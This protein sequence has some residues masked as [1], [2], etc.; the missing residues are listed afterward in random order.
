MRQKRLFYLLFLLCF[1][2]TISFSQTGVRFDDHFIDATMRVDYF[3]TGDARELYFSIDQIYKQ[4]G[5]A[6]NPEKL[7]DRSNGGMY[8][9]KVYSLSSNELIYSRG[10]ATIFGE[11]RTT[12]PASKG[13]KKTFHQTLLLPFPK[14]SI[15]FVIEG[16]D[17]NHQNLLCPVYSVKIDPKDV[18]II[19]HTPDPND[20][21]FTILENGHPHE[22]V[23]F[24]FVAEGYTESDIEKFQKDVVR[25]TDVLF[26][27]EPFQSQKQRF[28]VRGVFR[29]SS[30]SG[31]DQPNKE[32]FR[33]TAVSASFNAL[34]LARYLLIDDNK[35]LRDIASRV[36]YDSVIVIA[37]SERYGGG[38]IY[39]DYTM[40]TV[41]HS[42]SEEV[43]MHELGHAFGNLADEYFTSTVSYN[44]FYPPGIEPHEPNI[45][46]LLD[47]DNIKWAHL[48]TPGIEIPTPWGQDEMESLR[49][50][51]EAAIVELERK[52][53]RLQQNQPDPV[54]VQ[55]LKD[56][57]EKT[58]KSFNAR[59]KQIQENYQ[60]MY[61]GKIGVF[62]GAGYSPKGLYRSEVHVGMFYKGEYGPVSEEALLKKIRHLS[63]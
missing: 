51:R 19:Q 56:K 49:K 41:D 58:K 61:K 21:V 15:L 44:E 63:R 9:L 34:N 55:T 24:V 42:R 60:N 48:L 39:N 53:K 47:P 11:Y 3:Q 50:E 23:D 4:N 1:L 10:F 13:I 12:D 40:T 29:A 5:W 46:A 20:R 25:L 17:P 26:S 2:H 36:P 52:I 32:I 38:G 37:N 14:S 22:K 35:A 7:I 30:E 18:N 45:T 31:V 57:I 54:E 28:N 6:G 59:I 16:R 27:T 43:F 62:E 33:N 8:Y